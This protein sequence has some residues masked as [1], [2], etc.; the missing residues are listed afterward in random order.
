MIA[1]RRGVEVHQ[2]VMSTSMLCFTLK[3]KKRFTKGEG[4]GRLKDPPPATP[5]LRRTIRITHA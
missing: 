1:E 2:I 5:S 3:K 4:V